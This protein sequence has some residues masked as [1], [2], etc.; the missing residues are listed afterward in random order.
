MD[1]QNNNIKIIYGNKELKE[2]YNE[3]LKEELN[4]LEKKL[5]IN[6]LELKKINN[7]LE[8]IYQDKVN[9]IIRHEDFEKFYS[10]KIEEKTKILNKINVLEYEIKKQK[11]ELEK[12]DMNKILKQTK[13]I[14][15]LKNVTKEMY[16]KLI[17]K[18][19][20]DS[21]KNIFIKFKFEKYI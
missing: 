7:M 2:I 19:E 14:L 17:E 3:I 1:N 8:E 5:K 6:K 18:I 9:K 15:S 12:V 21:D 16:G 11:E 20:F 4:K 10:K 13:E